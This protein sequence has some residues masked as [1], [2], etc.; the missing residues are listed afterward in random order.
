MSPENAIIARPAQQRTAFCRMLLCMGG[1]GGLSRKA[2]GK[3]QGRALTAVLNLRELEALKL[4]GIL[5]EAAVEGKVARRAAAAIHRRSDGSHTRNLSDAGHAQKGP[6][7]ARSDRGV[8]RG[9]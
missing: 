9:E 2:R 4:S 7:V 8:V 5:S 3:P 1:E 6:H